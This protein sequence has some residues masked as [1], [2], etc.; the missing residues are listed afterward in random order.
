MMPAVFA[1]YLLLAPA[2]A[3]SAGLL[4][5]FSQPHVQALAPVLTPLVAALLSPAP[6]TLA[7]APAT[8]AGPGDEYT[9]LPDPGPNPACPPDMRLVEGIHDDEMERLCLQEKAHRCWNY[10][11]HATVSQ[12][13]RKQVRVCMDQFE[14]PNQRG[15][16][17]LVMKDFHQSQ[18][19]CAD[20][21]KRLCTEEEFETACEGPD[22]RPFFY[23]FVV[24]ASVCNTSKPWL[25]FD[26]K[27]LD[28]GGDKA[29][30]EVERLWQGSVSGAYERCRTRDGIYDLIGN[31]E[32]WVASRKGRRW[33]GAL[34][35]GFWAKPWVG[36]RG[37][38]DAH[39]P[40]FVFYEVGW[41][42]C[43]DPSGANPPAADSSA[44]P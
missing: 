11:P 36:C 19:W 30:K 3:W 8:S 34:M 43:A 1:P 17:P 31:V 33:P 23:G 42:C 37:T 9:P 44:R 32:E 39:R 4:P 29:R 2:L 13:D 5:T 35:G 38:N 40:S 25:A 14:A 18:R 28:S 24:D 21:G 16:R 12:G 7:S 20:R 27:A 15:A 6:A 26:A 22:L 41:R 10:V